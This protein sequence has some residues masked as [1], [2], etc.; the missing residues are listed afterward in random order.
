MIANV[1]DKRARPYRW[2]KVTAIVEATWHDNS[3]TDS[4]QA[5]PAAAPDEDV[6]YDAIEG[7]PLGEAIV[8]AQSFPG[9]VTLYI[10]DD[11]EGTGAVPL[12][13]S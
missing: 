6:A 2:Q 3:V 11:G 1:I 4:D 9:A 5:Q 13:L 12:P 8:W 7:V 10:S